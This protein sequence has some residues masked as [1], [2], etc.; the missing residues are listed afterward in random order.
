MKLRRFVFT[1]L[2]ACLLLA[3][4]L[5]SAQQTV[6]DLSSSRGSGVSQSRVLIEN[7]RVLVPVPNPF[8]PGTTT[9]VE[10]VYNVTFQLDTSN[11]HLV[12]LSISQTGGTGATNCAAASVQV[13]DAVQ[14][15]ARP[16]TGANVTIGTQTVATNASGVASFSGLAAGPV[17][18]STTAGGYVTATQTATLAC[19]GGANT[20]AVALSPSTGT[21]SLG[22]G[23]FRVILTWGQNPSD[24]DSHLTGPAAD[25]T[26]WHVYYGDK[27]AGDMCALDVDDTTSYGPETVTCPPTGNTSTSLRNGVYRY[28]VHHYSGSSR[29]DTSGASVRLE[30][31]NG[32]TYTYTPPA[33]AYLGSK[34]VW[35]VFELTVNNG[36]VSVAPVNTVSNVSSASSVTRAQEAPADFGQAEDAAALAGL[37]GK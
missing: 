11:N 3:G 9:T 34:D 13:F 12:P 31:G 18:V 16:I 32:R 37:P 10:S 30:F 14:G 25:G 4:S 27:T 2:A 19:T 28:S 20:V 6:I 29:I 21:S 1:P 26:R 17:S 7:I 36:S 5:A 15:S 35:T 23:Q 8:S 24:L 33:G 22:S